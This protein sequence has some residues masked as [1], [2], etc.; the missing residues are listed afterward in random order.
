M[1]T[2]TTSTFDPQSLKINELK[3]KTV[4][5]SGEFYKILEDRESL[6]SI[7]RSCRFCSNHPL[8]GGSGVCHCI[9]GGI[10]ATC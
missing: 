5:E 6:E 7:P 10:Q 3:Y 1:C 4:T 2:S 8:N 9:L